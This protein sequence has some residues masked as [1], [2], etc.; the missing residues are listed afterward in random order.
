ML[1]VWP[2][3]TLLFGNHM[4]ILQGFQSQC[5]PFLL[6][7]STFMMFLMIPFYD[8]I[9]YWFI[10]FI[11]LMALLWQGLPHLRHCHQVWMV[12]LWLCFTSLMH[13]L[14]TLGMEGAAP[15]PPPPMPGMHH[16]NDNKL[17]YTYSR[18]PCSVWPNFMSLGAS[19]DGIPPPPPPPGM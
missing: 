10:S 14:L 11:L 8:W 13:S 5:L 6:V 12:F 2:A 17:P 15:P 9:I 1:Q 7:M 18:H 19:M 16:T 4:V 3:I